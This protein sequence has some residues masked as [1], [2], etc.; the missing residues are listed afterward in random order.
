MI[1]D[2]NGAVVGKQRD[3]NGST[4]VRGVINIEAL[5]HHRANAQVTNWMKDVRTEMAQII[6]EQPI[7]PKNRYI[8]RIPGKHAE[9]KEVIDRQIALM[10]E[11]DIWKAPS[12]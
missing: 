12:K 8:D 3:T 5:R 1:V 11:R 7:Y 10:Q 6:Y 9:Y 2:Y 4:Y